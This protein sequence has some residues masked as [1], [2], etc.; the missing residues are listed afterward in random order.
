MKEERSV[1]RVQLGHLSRLGVRC[2]LATIA[3]V[4]NQFL[5]HR[6]RWKHTDDG[7]SVHS[8]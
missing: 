6:F 8:G 4:N 2:E 1:Q 5:G 3:I 7:N